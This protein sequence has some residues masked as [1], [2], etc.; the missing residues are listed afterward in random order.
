MARTK[1]TSRKKPGKAPAPKRPPSRAVALTGARQLNRHQTAQIAGRYVFKQ[2]SIQE[3]RDAWLQYRR[4]RPA[5]RNITFAQFQQTEQGSEYAGMPAV[6]LGPK[7]GTASG[8]KAAGSGALSTPLPLDDAAAAAP[9]AA[10]TVAAV[11]AVAASAAA[12][13]GAPAGDSCSSLPSA[14]PSV[15]AAL[16]LSQLLQLATSCPVDIP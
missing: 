14:S 16:S 9:A 5:Q 6:G 12:A 10:P 2:A 4:E 8:T 7:W 3:G 15:G 1:Q 11:V 13:A